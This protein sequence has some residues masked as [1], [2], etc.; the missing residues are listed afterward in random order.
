[1]VKD[2]KARLFF[3]ISYGHIVKELITDAAIQLPSAW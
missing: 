1:M 3:R 2:R